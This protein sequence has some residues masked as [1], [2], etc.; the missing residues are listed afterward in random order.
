M[1]LS[2]YFDKG[3]YGTYKQVMY[4]YNTLLTVF[5]FGLPR[6]YSYFIPKVSLGESKDVVRKISKIFIL[7]GFAFS[8]LLYGGASIIA[9]FLNNDD[10]VYALRVFSPTPL[11]LLP[12]MGLDCI[13]ASYQRTKLIAL[14]T[15]ATKVFTLLCIILPVMLFNGTYIHAI[16]G[17]DIASLLSFLLANYLKNIPTKGVSIN[18]TNISYRDIFSFTVPL[19]IASVW[20]MIFQSS[21][22]FFISRY[23]GNE[24][25][26]EFSNGFMD[27][28]LIPMVISSVATVLLPLFSGMVERDKE[29][30]KVAWINALSKTIKITYPFIVFCI[31]F[32]SLIMT[33]MYGQ[34]Y[35]SSSSYFVVKS[36]EGFFMVMP[37]YPILL[38]LG[39]SKEYSHIHLSMAIVLVVI[40]LIVVKLEY[41]PIAI[42]ISYVICSFGKVIM[43]FFAVS[44]S[45][46][47]KTYEFIP[48]KT[49]ATICFISFLSCIPSYV[50]SGML[51]ANAFTKFIIVL[52]LFVINYYML[53]WLF[54]LS[55]KEIAY[56]YLPS[57][58]KDSFIRL[59]P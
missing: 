47:V 9:S 52:A 49:M 48:V 34:Q 24:I 4:I 42:G 18:R 31:C 5:A 23:Y 55:Y 30:I 13:L 11:F 57:K 28:P 53:C 8:I 15:I 43:Q 1:I 14:Y 59:I 50:I 56:S 40:D 7:L 36:I 35:A 29:Q 20:I 33:C 6:A 54:H 38:A 46:N 3:D 32:S 26:A 51:E 2:R 41:P 37:F 39:K 21:N 58:L 27:L 10:L 16:I 44:K 22:Q 25:F 45:I 12:V 17:F 19:I